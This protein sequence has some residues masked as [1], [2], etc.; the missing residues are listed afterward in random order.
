MGKED[1]EHPILDLDLE[2]IL[3]LQ[4]AERPRVYPLKMILLTPDE[5]AAVI[6]VLEEKRIY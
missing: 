4:A 6:P 2:C 5:E 3:G 1:P